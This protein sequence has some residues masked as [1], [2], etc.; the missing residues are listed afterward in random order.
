MNKV[1]IIGHGWVG[2]A[3]GKLFPTAVIYDP[4][5]P[6]SM[7]ADEY[8]GKDEVNECD[9]AF[10]CVP[11]PNTENGALDTSIVEEVVSWC[12]C[13]LLVIRSTV[14]PGTTDELMGKYHKNI[15]MQPEFLGETP[16]HPFYDP[17]TRNFM[18]I[19]GE[20]KDRR[21]LINL[22]AT[23]YNSNVTIRQL[24]NYEAEVCKLTENRAIG[25]KVMQLH[26]LYLACEKA[27]ID[28][29]TIRDTVY[30]DDPRFDL[31]FSFIYENN[32]GFSS[33]KCLKKDVLAWASWAESIGIDP[34]LTRML[35][36]KSNDYKE[37]KV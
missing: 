25:F 23:V 20:P 15:I 21:E 1:A 9:V 30:G 16:N 22:Y 34:E 32:L 33:S 29:Y 35:I 5:M 24:T 2:K 27:N 37:I 19:G 17:K 14:N 12:A 4:A 7:S 18:V 6:D 28:Y 11:T 3:M 31:W 10:I 13:P 36:K 26:E 8:L